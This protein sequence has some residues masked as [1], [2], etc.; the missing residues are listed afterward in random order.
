MRST[1]FEKNPNVKINKNS[2]Q[3]TYSILEIKT[4]HR[5]P[6]WKTPRTR[7]RTRPN[8]LAGREDRKEKQFPRIT[9]T[10][11][12]QNFNNFTSR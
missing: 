1:K 3:K 6:D 12:L 8:G 10:N 4:V 2:K 7:S 9:K 11:F 5:S